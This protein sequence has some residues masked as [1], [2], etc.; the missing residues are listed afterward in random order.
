MVFKDRRKIYKYIFL[1]I[2]LSNINCVSCQSS[3]ERIDISMSLSI[4][5]I[6]HLN[7]PFITKDTTEVAVFRVKPEVKPDS[8]LR[9]IETKEQSYLEVRYLDKNIWYELFA[10]IKEHRYPPLFLKVHLYSIPISN[11]F[12]N[13][14]LKVFAETISLNEEMMKLPRKYDF[15]DGTFYGFK[16]NSNGKIT[17][18]TI[19]DDSELYQKTTTGKHDL[20]YLVKTTNL[21]IINDVRNGT[22]NE[23]KYEIYK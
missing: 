7:P 11:S 22:F 14:I 21:R 19:N 23:S 12:K 5:L 1:A 3:K 15:F 2:Y 8:S 18:T 4:E 17:E 13:R 20:R 10:S 6:N 9:V 16:I